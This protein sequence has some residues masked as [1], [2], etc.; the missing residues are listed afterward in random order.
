MHWIIKE[1]VSIDFYMAGLGLY[2][3]NLSLRFESD[4]PDVDYNELGNDVEVDIT[5]IPLIGEKTEIEVGD[6]YVDA[7]SS[8]I[9]P[10]FRTGIS[11]GIVF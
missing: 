10:G 11:I 7:K 2:Y 3:D 4:D 8:F 5:G 9:F 6:D 1:K